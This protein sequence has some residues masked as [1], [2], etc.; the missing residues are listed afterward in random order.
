LH[1]GWLLTRSDFNGKGWMPVG[2]HGYHPD[3]SYSD[4]VFLS[5]K[6]PAFEIT[7]IDE[8]QAALWGAPAIITAQEVAAR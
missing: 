5:N 6:R 8:V 4:A 7:R 2:M 1:P 3:D